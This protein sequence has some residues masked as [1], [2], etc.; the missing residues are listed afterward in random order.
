MK[1]LAHMN[2]AI[3]LSTG[4]LLVLL[5]GPGRG[6]TSTARCPRAAHHPR[7]HAAA[8]IA[9]IVCDTIDGPPCFVV[10]AR[11][12]GKVRWRSASGSI[13]D[14]VCTPDGQIAAVV[15]SDDGL[16]TRLMRCADP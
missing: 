13:S 14:I 5:C 10:R 16:T 15:W 4:L 3:R 6:A 7:C 12:D 8:G 11:V 9:A 1:N 2:R